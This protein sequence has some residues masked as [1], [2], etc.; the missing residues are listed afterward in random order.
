MNALN[1]GWDLI[2]KK[3]YIDGGPALN[4]WEIPGLKTG[5][6]VRGTL[7]HA[8]D[9]DSGWSVEIAI[10]WKVLGEFSKQKAPP[11]EGDGWR[12]DFS[13]VEWHI[14]IRDGRYVKVPGKKEDNWV[15]SPTGIIDMHRPENWGYVKFTSQRGGSYQA[16]RDATVDTLLGLYY[17]QKYFHGKNK[18]WA[19]SLKELGGSFAGVKLK[20]TASG[21]E[22]TLSGK[23]IREDGLLH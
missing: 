1:T 3:A 2:L 15:W 20:K 6:Q 13:R 12:V 11:A 7:N 9:K 17:A 22:A 4:A 8:S 21:Y 23:T 19:E 10:P 16:K 14:D 5:V 18:R